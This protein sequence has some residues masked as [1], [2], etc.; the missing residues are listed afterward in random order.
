MADIC[1]HTVILYVRDPEHSAAFYA[2][3]FGLQ[4]ATRDGGMV[5]LRGPGGAG[6]LLHPAAKSARLGQAGMKLSFA[7]EDVVGFIARA[8]ERGLMFGPVHKAEGYEFAN[9]KDPDGHHLSISSR[10]MRSH[11]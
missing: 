11:L 1:L 5:E 3:H 9:A 7:V 10:S 4:I 8:A 2:E 6:L